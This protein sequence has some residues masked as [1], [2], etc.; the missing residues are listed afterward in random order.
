MTTSRGDLVSEYE[1]VAYKLSVNEVGGP[2]KTEYG[3]HLIKLML[4]IKNINVDAQ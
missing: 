2:V 4:V 1:K 3:Y